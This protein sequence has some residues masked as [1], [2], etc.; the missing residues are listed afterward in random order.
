MRTSDA[1]DEAARIM[2]AC[3]RTIAEVVAMERIAIFVLA[4]IVA[5]ALM[6]ALVHP[7]PDVPFPP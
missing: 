6:G 7:P 1:V 4:A 3:T 2:S 5:L